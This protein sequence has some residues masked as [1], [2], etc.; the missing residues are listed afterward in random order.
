M[1]RHGLSVGLMREEIIGEDNERR[2]ALYTPD[3]E[4]FAVIGLSGTGDV[5]KSNKQLAF[6]KGFS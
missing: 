3:N 4:E 1:S 5:T 2:G 6:G